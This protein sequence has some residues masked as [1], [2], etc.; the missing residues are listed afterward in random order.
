MAGARLPL[1]L[2]AGITLQGRQACSAPGQGD[3]LRVIRLLGP[4]GD[5]GASPG[6]SLD[7]T[8]DA[9]PKDTGEDHLLN[10]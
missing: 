9:V 3:D 10:T 5:R 1:T 8:C 4:E 7:A 2:G 6:E